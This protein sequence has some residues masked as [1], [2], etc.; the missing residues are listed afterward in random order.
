MRKISK[1]RGAGLAQKRKERNPIRKN[2]P[3][4]VPPIRSNRDAWDFALKQVRLIGVAAKKH[5]LYSR[6]SRCSRGD[7]DSILLFSL[8]YSSQRYDSSRSSFSTYFLSDARRCIKDVV[9]LSGE[10]PLYQSQQRKVFRVVNT[11]KKHQT[12]FEDALDIMGLSERSKKTMRLLMPIFINAENR[13]DTFSLL[14][15][16]SPEEGARQVGCSGA[17]SA[18]SEPAQEREITSEQLSSILKKAVY[19]LPSAYREII[20]LRFG[21]NGHTAHNLQEIGDMFSLSRERIRQIQQE[22]FGRIRESEYAQPLKDI[23][24]SMG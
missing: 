16:S 13:P 21:L 9:M 5:N 7:V 6:S 18:C 12:G 1:P 4:D 23:L 22:A 20:E 3:K 15:S 19:S 2:H 24:E 8:F 14:Y 11:M 17:A 10:I